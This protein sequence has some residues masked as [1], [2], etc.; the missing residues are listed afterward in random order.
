MEKN[1]KTQFGIL[2]ATFFLSTM[3]GMLIVIMGIKTIGSK[4]CAAQKNA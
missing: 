3:V 1:N 4:I 2:L